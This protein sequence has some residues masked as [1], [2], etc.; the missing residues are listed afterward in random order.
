MRRTRKKCLLKRLT[1]ETEGG[2]NTLITI[3]ENVSTIIS[4][5]KE[6]G[7]EAWIVGGCVRDALLGRTPNDWDVTT[8]A[9]PDDVYSV[10]EGKG[11]TVIRDFG[12]KHG[13]VS[14]VFN[15]DGIH[16]LYEITT[17]RV[18]GEYSD[19]R[20][21]DS[22]SFVS[23]LDADLSRRDFTINAMASDGDILIDPYGG[24]ND[25]DRNMI[26]AVGEP[27]RRFTEDALRILR[28]L[29]FSSQLGFEIEDDTLCA[30]REC[31]SLITNVSA[32]RRAAELDKLLAGPYCFDVITK[33]GEIL[34][35]CVGKSRERSSFKPDTFNNRISYFFQLDSD[36]RFSLYFGDNAVSAAKGL[37]LSKDRIR[38]IAMLIEAAHSEVPEN[39]AD[40]LRFMRKFP[41]TVECLKFCK[42]FDPEKEISNAIEMIKSLRKEKACYSLYD[43]NLNGDDLISAGY[44]G[45][46]VG[47]ALEI[48]L[49]AVIEGLVPND[50]YALL[51]YLEKE[52]SKDDVFE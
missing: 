31:S 30:M 24:K 20:H 49:D 34:D 52:K 16:N 10:L 38:T 19:G 47:K 32:E 14:A 7:F 37:K 39:R 25:L 51:A 27:E 1:Y 33:Y 50:K 45:P 17:Y 18:D 44:S 9:L 28:A 5:L 12:L 26:R 23:S 29:R 48:S 2:E 42:L 6:R 36:A 11:I 35:I 13:T 40:A 21:P 15:E 41:F 3:P 8:S 46:A 4:S 22:V 43:L